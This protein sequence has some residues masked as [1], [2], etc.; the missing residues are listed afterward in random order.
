MLS[1][2]GTVTDIGSNARGGLAIV[3]F[4]EIGLSDFTCCSLHIRA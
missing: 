2:F 3:R 1:A 4:G